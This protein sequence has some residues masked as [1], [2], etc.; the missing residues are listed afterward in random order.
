MLSSFAIVAL[1]QSLRTGSGERR[2]QKSSVPSSTAMTG[3]ASMD[4]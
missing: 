2:D 1:Q 4:L 3:I